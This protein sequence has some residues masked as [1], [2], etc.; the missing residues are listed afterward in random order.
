ME[1]IKGYEQEYS[2]DRE[3]NVFGFKRGKYLSTR[4]NKGYTVVGLCKN[5]RMK[6]HKIHRLIATQFIPNPDGK[7][8]VNHINGIKTDNR[9]ENLE[10]AT[11]QE[12]DSHAHKNGLKPS[13][14]KHYT[15]VPVLDV[16]MGIFYGNLK[17]AAH[18]KNIKYTTLVQAV[19]KG[20]S[21]KY[22]FQP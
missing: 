16:T 14:S 20:Y 13:G 21:L 1:P 7:A 19:K 15:A 12:N 8:T 2:I 9:I 10:W 22:G 5:N 4:L 18:A 3:G 17:E 11:Q 6:T